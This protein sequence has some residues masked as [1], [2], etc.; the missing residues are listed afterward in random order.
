MEYPSRL[1]PDP[2]WPIITDIPVE[3]VLVR[4]VIPEV[5][6]RDEESGDINPAALSVNHLFTYSANKIPPTNLKDIKIEIEK[7]DYYLADW[8]PGMEPLVPGE[9]DFHYEEE[10]GF[11]VF[12]IG[13]I[14]LFTEKP[15]YKNNTGITTRFFRLK[16]IHKPKRCN[17]PHFEFQIENE[18]GEIISYS[19]S[20]WKREIIHAIRDRLIHI[21]SLR[22]DDFPSAYQ[23]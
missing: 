12:K 5:P 21:I 18:E 4:W 15:P 10:R 14:H 1:L 9:N 2:T 11:F 6:I 23:T 17:Y 3:D 7:K 19:K 22:L 20:K 16:V 13:D 8:K